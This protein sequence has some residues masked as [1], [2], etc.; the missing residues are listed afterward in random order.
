MQV[1]EAAT[2]VVSEVMVPTL[3]SFIDGLT[4]VAGF[5]EILEDELNSVQGKT[6]SAIESKIERKKKLHYR[7]VNKKAEV[8]KKHCKMFMMIL[9]EM[10]TNFNTIPIYPSDKNYVDTWLAERKAK[11]KNKQGLDSANLIEYFFTTRRWK[12]VNGRWQKEEE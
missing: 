1:N 10:R 8:I 4:S 6:K 12:M 2:N 5:F 7:M 11:I 9:P 3:E